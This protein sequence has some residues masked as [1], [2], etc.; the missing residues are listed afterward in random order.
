MS[1]HERSRDLVQAARGEVARS[2]NAPSVVNAI[3]S[4]HWDELTADEDLLRHI[5]A[6]GLN[7][8]VR[9][10]LTRPVAGEESKLLA[11]RAQLALWPPGQREI[12]ARIN[13]ER[14][15][16]PSREDFVELVPDAMTD[17][18]LDEAGDYLIEHGEDAVQRGR[19]IKRLAQM[20]RQSAA[21]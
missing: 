2:D 11:D 7:A 8:I 13:R 1:L 10:V 15:F 4:L 9:E 12:V 3:L 19:A 14:V 16:V 20:R 21:A 6:R 18:E 17:A 5:V